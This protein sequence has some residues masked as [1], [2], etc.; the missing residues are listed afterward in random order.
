MPPLAPEKVPPVKE[1]IQ[2]T[3]AQRLALAPRV[4]SLPP[5]VGE[6]KTEKP[7][8]PSEVSSWGQIIPFYIH[9]AR[10]HPPETEEILRRVAGGH[11]GESH[12][13]V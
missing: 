12:P 5:K 8:E 3:E 9:Q 11:G 4:P 13:I 2:L 6:V 1:W 10:R 7:V